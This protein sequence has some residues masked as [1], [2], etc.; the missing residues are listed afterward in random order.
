MSRERPV[1]EQGRLHVVAAV[2]DD[3]AG[4]ILIA[5]RQQHL[6]QGGLWEF[7][8][9]KCEPD[10]VPEAALVREL[11]EELGITATAFRHLIDIVHD[12]PDRRVHLDVWRVTAFSGQPYGAEGQEVVWVDAAELRHLDFPAANAPIIS[13]ALLP[14]CYLITPEP[15]P[16]DT[17]PRFLRQLELSLRRG[18]SL[19]QLRAKELEQPQ[20]VQLAPRVIELCHSH[21]ARVLL[22]GEPGV[23]D[24]LGFDGVHL[25]GRRLSR[26]EQRP[27]QRDKLLAASCHSENELRMAAMVEC[28]F[29]V[30]SPVAATASHPGVA[31]MGWQRFSELV[32]NA[33]MPVFALGGMRHEDLDQAWRYGAQGI[34]AIGGLWE[35][36]GED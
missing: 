19:V 14:A 18:V 30:L 12:Y 9:G 10:E 11:Q 20:L 36:E 13:A 7:P 26:C 25:D 33:G 27:L 29:A 24:E 4:H 28:D 8:G 17:W 6:H 5:R 3:D 31:G 21:A 35:S 1:V 15:G 22:N 32:G 34:A 16:C 23:A 2:I